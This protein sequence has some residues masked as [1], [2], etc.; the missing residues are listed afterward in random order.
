MNEYE[1]LEWIHC[2]IQET[3]TASSGLIDTSDLFQALGFIEDIREKY[4]DE[5]GNLAKEA[6]Q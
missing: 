6:K 1:K 4:F 3:I 2:A 5:H